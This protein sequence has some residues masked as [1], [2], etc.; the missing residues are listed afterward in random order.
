MLSAL[1]FGE[2]LNARSGQS[3]EVL[4]AELDRALR[5]VIT[6]LGTEAGPSAS[7]D[8][9]ALEWN[10]I[11]QTPHDYQGIAARRAALLFALHTLPPVRRHYA[12]AEPELVNDLERRVL[13]AVVPAFLAGMA[14]R[15]EALVV[16]TSTLSSMWREPM[17]EEGAVPGAPPRQ[18]KQGGPE[19]GEGARA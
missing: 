10:R 8:Q 12:Q 15:P 14:Q 17:G 3:V 18:G 1:L 9:A 6:L 5:G 7:Y 19:Q 11:L 13:P 16:L 4:G 2:P